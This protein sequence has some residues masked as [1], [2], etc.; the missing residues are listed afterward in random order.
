MI[1][2]SSSRMIIEIS[3]DNNIY[4]NNNTNKLSNKFTRAKTIR[5]QAEREAREDA[6]ASAAA[7]WRA[8]A[9]AELLQH[10]AAQVSCMC[11][12]ERERERECVCVC[13][14]LS[15]CV[16]VCLCVC[17]CVCVCV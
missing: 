11:V 5:V 15:V 17:V 9:V 14:C 4:S 1:S 8:A 3:Q 16:C 7:V 6:A 2:S 10:R 12:R 13:V